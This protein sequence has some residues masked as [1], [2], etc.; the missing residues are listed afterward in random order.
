MASTVTELLRRRFGGKKSILP[1]GYTQIEFVSPNRSITT[2]IGGTGTTWE[3]E[4]QM[5]T[6]PSSW[7]IIIGKSD[8]LGNFFGA[9]N[10]GYFSIGSTTA[11]DFAPVTTRC[12]FVVSFGQKSVTVTYNGETKTYERASVEGPQNLTLFD[13]TNYNVY[14]YNGRC[15][16]IK[17]TSGASFNGIPAQRDSDSHQ[18][19]YDIDNDVFYDLT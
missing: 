9:K 17:C 12:K 13:A 14:Q 4:V 8:Y 18:G 2:Q 16:G 7:Q 10:N 5:E 1:E 19:L 6:T 15:Y 3:V 11:Y